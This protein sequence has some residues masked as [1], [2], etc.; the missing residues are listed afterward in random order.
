MERAGRPRC[1]PV[2]GHLLRGLLLCLCASAA[3]AQDALRQRYANF[4]GEPVVESRDDGHH[5]AG[6]IYGPL[7]YPFEAVASALKEPSNWCEVL[8]LHL[9]TKECRVVK[10]GASTML[11]AG[12]V[13]HYD[14]PASTAYRVELAYRLARDTPEYFDAHL[15]ADDGP[16]DTSDFHIVFEAMRTA[17]GRTF[18]HMS[19]SYAYGGLSSLALKLYLVTFGRGKVG[20]T[21]VGD[22][23][24]SPRYIGGMRGVVERNTMRY[25]LAVEAWL[26]A[27]GAPR[28]VRMERALRNWYSAV[29]RYPRQLHELSES[30]YLDMKRK[31]L[32]S[33]PN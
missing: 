29:E 13:T 26:G 32:G 25:Y 19:Y 14:Q 8:L 17:D 27:M 6:E 20:F 12:V 4:H 33:Y 2:M 7:P 21:V 1:S 28:D 22:D 15:D 3:H 18:A 31:E 11:Q 24:G 10:R 30:R 5:A 23:N 16:A 9:D